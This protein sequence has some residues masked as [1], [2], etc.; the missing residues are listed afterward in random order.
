MQRDR[1][2]ML[3]L[4]TTNQACVC[5]KK[6]LHP[7][8]GHIHEYTSF[9]TCLLCYERFGRTF[10]SP[11]LAAAFI[12]EIQ[13]TTEL[14]LAGKAVNNGTEAYSPPTNSNVADEEM[15]N[16]GDEV[17]HQV[18]TTNHSLARAR[19]VHDVYEAMTPAKCRKENRSLSTRAKNQSEA[20]RLVVW[21]FG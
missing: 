10:E 21:L 9:L 4:V 7:I 13:A 2:G 5:C 3:P 6:V 17:V 8:C 14:L 1:C 16:G 15:H 12:D 18:L 20:C 19:M 11:E